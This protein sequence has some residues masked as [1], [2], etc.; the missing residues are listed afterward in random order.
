MKRYAINELLKWKEKKVRK[1]LLIQGAKQVG[2][3]WLM[4]EFGKTY[5]KQVAYL[6]FNDNKEAKDIFMTSYNVENIISSIA[7]LTDTKIIP[8]ETLII[9]DEIQECD[10]ALNVLKFFREN[11]PEYHIIAAGSLLGVALKH[12]NISFPVGQVEFLELRPLSFLEFLQALEEENLVNLFAAEKLNFNLI[13]LVHS[14]LITLLKQYLIIGGMPE[15]VSTYLESK[16]YNQV[17]KI[18][19]QILI[20][21]R[22]DFSKYIGASYIPRINAVWDSIPYQLAKENKKFTY[23][24]V[25]KGARAREYE[26]AIEW[27]ILCGLVHRVHKV[28]KPSLPL[29]SYAESSAFKLYLLD[30]GLLCAKALLEPQIIIE[31]N[32][33]FTEFKGSLT[34][35]YVLQE[36]KNIE[37][38]PLAYWATDTGTAEIDFIFQHQGQIIPLEVKA[39]I[40]LKARSL[41]SYREK[42]KQKLAVRASLA[43]YK[44]ENQLF[45]IPLY[46]IGQVGEA[47]FNKFA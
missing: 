29:S 31:G 17:R 9:L 3:T 27:L 6:S 20:G 4:K 33:I 40:N 10:S 37:D 15:A 45:D 14:K 34:E 11:A 5:Y 38:L 25:A 2:K 18:Q 30:C 46:L 8:S 21:Y 24:K 35:Q 36:L 32:D 19:K 22:N 28:S 26:E 16:D 39:T 47:I 43:N 23:N 44:E 1:P 7:L 42:Y 13:A 41:A 12:K